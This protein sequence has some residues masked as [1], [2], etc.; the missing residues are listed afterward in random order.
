MRD[1]KAFCVKTGELSEAFRPN[2]RQFSKRPTRSR[3]KA[4][5]EQNELFAM[6]M[7]SFEEINE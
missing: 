3:K 2:V 1:S 5:N 4:R 6:V 7:N